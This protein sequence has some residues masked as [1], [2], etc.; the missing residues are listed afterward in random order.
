VTKAVGGVGR[1]EAG[2]STLYDTSSDRDR[3]VLRELGVC[4]DISGVFVSAD[5]T[6]VPTELAERMIAISAE[7]MRAIPEVIVIP[8]G[9]RKAPAVRAALRSG[10]VSGIVT[11]TSL[12]RAVLDGT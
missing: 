10:L 1:W 11:H 5:G 9:L 7:E 2:Q 8:Y 3:R 12:A 4:A 6:P